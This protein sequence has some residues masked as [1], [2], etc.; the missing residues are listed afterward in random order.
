MLDLLLAGIMGDWA[1][2]VQKRYLVNLDNPSVSWF[3]RA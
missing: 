3:E 1:D 2:Q